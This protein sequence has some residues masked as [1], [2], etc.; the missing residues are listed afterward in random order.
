MKE[1]VSL[2]PE[3]NARVDKNL[4]FNIT[5]FRDFKE[6]EPLIKALILYM[7]VYYQKNLFG[8]CTL[9]PYHFMEVMSIHRSFLFK[10]H[11]NPLQFRLSKE[12]KETLIELEKKHGRRSIHRLWDSY[13][14]NALFILNKETVPFSYVTSNKTEKRIVLQNFTYI[15]SLE[16]VF[17][18]T[19]KTYKVFYEYE[20]SVEF[21]ENLRKFFLPLN[22]N[23]YITLRAKN[24]EDCY[25]KL[26]NRIQG[27]EVKQNYKILYGIKEFSD[28]LNIDNSRLSSPDG[29]SDIKKKINYKFRKRFTPYVLKEIP[30]LNLKWIKGDGAKYP[31]VAVITWKKKSFAIKQ[32]ETDETHDD[33]F[34]TELFKDLVKFFQNNNFKFEENEDIILNG[35]LSW[36]FSF[37][38]FEIKTSKYISEHADHKG[39]KKNLE[40]EAKEFF[41]HLSDLEKKQSEFQFIKCINGIFYVTDNEGRERE[42]RHF[43]DAIQVILNNYKYFSTLEQ[44]IKA[45]C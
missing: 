15:K 36:L 1:V 12:P 21:A 3:T 20:P 39:S 23:T 19:N 10:K 9:D 26:I 35:F 33:I 2:L 18:K 32:K 38:D 16:A 44:K 17:K 13:L 37:K 43:K 34:F 7:S 28:I 42:M 27:E 6:D 31:N 11:S 30:E 24:L 45:K 29:F 8:K 22:V 5:E 41:M 40:K 4:A 25:L 14:E